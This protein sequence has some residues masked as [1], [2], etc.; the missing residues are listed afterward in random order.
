MLSLVQVEQKSPG[1]LAVYWSF[2]EEQQ[3]A[4]PSK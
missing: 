3:V 2:V 1:Y 4:L